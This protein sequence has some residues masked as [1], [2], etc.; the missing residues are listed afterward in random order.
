V[1]AAYERDG[2]AFSYMTQFLGLTLFALAIVKAVLDGEEGPKVAH[3]A[4]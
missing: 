4:A 1:T 3:L 2:P